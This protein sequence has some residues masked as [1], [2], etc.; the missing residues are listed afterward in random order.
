MKRFS[1]ALSN[2]FKFVQPRR[3]L[4][5]TLNKNNLHNSF[6]S[7]HTNFPIF[8]QNDRNANETQNLIDEISKAIREQQYSKAKQTLRGLTK[9]WLGFYKF[10][11]NQLALYL[12][13]LVLLDCSNNDER[14]MN[15]TPLLLAS[16]NGYK[17]AHLM[18]ATM[19]YLKD[20]NLENE[21]YRVYLKEFDESVDW[22]D[23]TLVQLTIESY[24]KELIQQFDSR[25]AHFALGKFYMKNQKYQ[26]ACEAFTQSTEKKFTK[27]QFELGLL[28]RN[29]SPDGMVSKNPERALELFKKSRWEPQAHKELVE[30]YLNGEG[31]DPS[32]LK[33]A[34]QTCIY[35]IVKFV[36]SRFFLVLLFLMELLLALMEAV[37]SIVLGIVGIF[38]V[39][40]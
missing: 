15:L 29:G 39:L 4:P 27:S 17:K 6:R 38:G 24:L 12:Q 36:N 40:V 23:E 2:T 33:A 13:S 32:Y 35:Y 37:L 9:N 30:M 22:N 7:F 3:T 25:F 5:N 11:D 8:N 21:N 14:K 20:S 19:A 28:M 10:D 31:T 1:C 18:L 34:F 26:K 16:N